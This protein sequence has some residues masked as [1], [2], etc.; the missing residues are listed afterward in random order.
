M[1]WD[2]KCRPVG[3]VPAGDSVTVPVPVADTV[4]EDVVPTE[5]SA[6]GPVV[7][8]GA[9]PTC[10]ESSSLAEPAADV[11]VTSTVLSDS[12]V[13]VPVTG[14]PEMVTAPLPSVVYINPVGSDPPMTSAGNGYPAAVTVHDPIRPAAN[15]HADELTKAGTWSTTTVSFW[16]TPPVAT[17][18]MF[19]ALSVI[20]YVP[21][22]VGVPVMVAR[23]TLPSVVNVRPGGSVPATL[24]IDTAGR[25]VAVTVN[26]PCRPSSMVTV[27]GLV[28]SGVPK[29]SSSTKAMPELDPTFVA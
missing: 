28:N 11:A 18:K 17:S 23:L 27:L 20:V 12:V 14:V 19:V 16:S 2:A 4:N 13:P 25:P 29:S 10:T 8:A 1:P 15:T 5:K 24:A 6:V 22:F 26:V 21:S 7:N 3:K 9:G